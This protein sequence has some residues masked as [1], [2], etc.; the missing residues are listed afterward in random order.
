MRPP[1]ATS[2]AANLSRTL[3]K[4]RNGQ[5]LRMIL[6]GDSISAGF[7][8]SGVLGFPPYQASWGELLARRL[9]SAYGSAIA[10]ENPAL[11]GAATDWGLANIDQNVSSHAP[12][13]VILAFGMNDASGIVAVG[14]FKTNIQMMVAS[15]RA[16][17]PA[18]IILVS[19]ILPVPNDGVIPNMTTTL[20]YRAPYRDALRDVAAS[21]QTALVDMTALHQWLI[22]W[23]D[24]AA[25]PTE[26]PKTFLDTMGTNV[27]HPGDWLIRWYAEELG[28]L[29]VPPAAKV[30]EDTAIGNADGQISYSGAWSTAGSVHY[31]LGTDTGAYALVKFTGTHIVVHGGRNVDRGIAEYAICDANGASCASATLVDAYASSLQVDQVSWISPS[32]SPGAHSLRIRATHSKNAASSG[33]IVDVDRVVV[34]QNPV[35]V[36]DD[37]SGSLDDQITYSGTWS[38]A[39]SVHYNNGTTATDYLLL[40]FTGNQVVVYSGGNVDRG[41]AAYSIC[42]ASGNN[43]G[44]ETFVDRYSPTLQIGVPWASPI[45]SAGPQTLKIRATGTKSSAS[46]GKIVDIDSVVVN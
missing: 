9:N 42:D 31:S 44:P 40:R 6:F 24:S 46:S 26:Q 12:D 43:C 17:G 25:S 22:G 8:A 36:N 38:T 1:L 41:I 23:P 45:L 30:I 3:N 16:A 5:P 15:V 21:Q 14:D 33:F 39:G 27:N 34:S 7:Q 19:P 29:L 37:D 2:G 32:L 4:L 13:L 35:T 10:F 28:L 18:E 11:A 20:S